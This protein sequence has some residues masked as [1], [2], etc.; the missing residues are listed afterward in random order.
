MDPRSLL[1]SAQNIGETPQG[2]D[3]EP[4]IPTDI[5]SHTKKDFGEQFFQS[6][7][8]LP[9]ANLHK[10]K[11]EWNDLDKKSRSFGYKRVKKNNQGWLLKTMTSGM[12]IRSLNLLFKLLILLTALYSHQLIGVDFMVERE[13]SEE[14]PHGGILADDMV[15]LIR[16]RLF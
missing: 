16:C 10:C 2:E 1:P 9:K 3:E 15:S 11:T 13:C 14:R 8:A 5:K 6:L 7:A 12:P 4:P